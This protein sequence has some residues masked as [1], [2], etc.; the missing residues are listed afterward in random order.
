MIVIDNKICLRKADLKDIDALY[1]IKND[2]EATALL[3]GFSNGYSRIDIENWI[4]SHNNNKNE[5]LYLIE[6]VEG[7]NV[8][9]HVGL[10]NIDFRVRKAEFAILIAGDCNQ[11][12]GYGSLCTKFM[13]DYAFNEL[14]IR[15][16]TLSLL[17]DNIRAFS[18]YKK[19][20][21]VQEGLLKDEQF[22]KGKYHDVILMAL[23][24]KNE[25]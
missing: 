7:S 3:G 24:K 6:T 25:Q 10:Y 18:L 11:G 19:Y 14:N 8:I 22:K 16:I 23:F 17:S 5:V 15:K 1:E 9:G 2:K 20:G 21:F 13:I 4:I 12:K